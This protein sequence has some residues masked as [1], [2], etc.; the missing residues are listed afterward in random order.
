MA[1]TTP[2]FVATPKIGHARVAAAN[3]AADGSGALATLFTAGA[4]GSRVDRITVRNSQ[5]SAAASSANVVRVFVTDTS[6]ANP[7]LYA[8]AALAAATRSNSVIGATTT[9]TFLG[10]LVLASGQLIQVCQA[11]YAGVQDQID[12]TAEGGD[13]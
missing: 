9:I 10:G 13:Y 3:T 7:R 1:N 8:E 6:G 11:V 4:D 2:I 12:Y 5:A